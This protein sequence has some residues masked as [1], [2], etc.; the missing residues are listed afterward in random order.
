L[1]Q[2]EASLTRTGDLVGTFRYMSP[3]QASGQRT[4]I[5]HRTDLYSLGAT[6]YEL[7]TLQ[8]VFSGETSPS[9]RDGRRPPWMDSHSQ[10]DGP[11]DHRPPP[12]FSRRR[13][14]DARRQPP[15]DD[16]ADGDRFSRDDR[17]DDRERPRDRRPPWFEREM[18]HHGPPPARYSSHR[19]DRDADRPP[20]P[21]RGHRE[22]P[23]RDDRRYDDGADRAEY[24]PP[25]R[26]RG[27]PRDDQAGEREDRPHDRGDRRR[28][29]RRVDERPDR[30]GDSAQP[31]R[32]NHD[33]D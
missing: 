11:R 21:W 20:P 19:P 18:G 27:P 13:P 9:E 7:L 17:E 5:D 6:F 32:R 3:E 8:P 33:E 16:C 28:P 14:P 25:P 15:R 22:P 4:A 29:P 24:A 12:S 1:F 23:P 31:P 30:D 26:R 2:A 10:D